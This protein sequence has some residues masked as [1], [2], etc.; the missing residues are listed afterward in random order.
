MMT[1]RWFTTGGK[2]K[3]KV[4]W[5][6]DQI[7][8]LRETNDRLRV[9]SKS[10]QETIVVNDRMIAAMVLKLNEWEVNCDGRPEE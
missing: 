9:E 2:T 4:V 7:A 6:K 5:L 8:A 3:E 10:I 1:S